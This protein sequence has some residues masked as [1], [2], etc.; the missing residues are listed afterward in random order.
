MWSDDEMT[1]LKC[2]E[3]SFFSHTQDRRKD[4]LPRLGG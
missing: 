4:L 1:E 3:V 2:T